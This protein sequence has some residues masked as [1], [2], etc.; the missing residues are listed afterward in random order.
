MPFE[1]TPAVPEPAAFAPAAR[2]IVVGGGFGGIAAALRLRARGYEVTLHDR[3]ERLGGRAAVFE[4][5][6]FRHDAG[7]TV[8]CA[9]RLFEELFALFGRTL[10]D[11]VTL[12]APDPWYR[13]VYDDGSSFDYGPTRDA[14]EREIARLSPGDVDNYA[15]LLDFS[16]AVHDVAFTQLSDRPFHDP[17]FMARQV[18]DLLR[19]QFYRTVWDVARR[20]FD[21]ERLARAFAIQPLLL[22]GNPLTTTSIYSLVSWLEHDQGVWFAMGGTGALVDALWDLMEDVGIDIRLSSP[23]AEIVVENGAARG[24]VLE[25]GRRE[26]AE[27]VVSNC[28]P[29]HLYGKMLPEGAAGRMPRLRMRYGQPSMGLFVLYFGATRQWPEVAHHTIQFSERF[30]GLLSDIFDHG[31][32][33]GDLSLYVHRP[34]ATDPS[35]APEGCDSFYVLCP[36]PNLR[37]EGIDWEV[38]APRLR[39]AIVDKLDATLLPGLREAITAEFRMTPE[40]FHH[41]YA[42]AHGAGFSLQ[43]LFRQSAF[44]RF[45]NRGEG[46]RDLYL[47][48]AGT[49]PGAG[50]PGVVL[51]A[52]V[53]D[54]LVPDAAAR[55]AG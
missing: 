53:L 26:A 8:L 2:A 39:D 33:S 55:E 1:A 45:H 52:K 43:P 11:H 5:E 4:N 12:V 25:D 36:V 10:S 50:V 24:V 3:C 23:V 14:T 46:I 51:S 54:S 49:H 22:G 31:R 19:L 42:S 6:G 34:T 13:F 18:P 16:R 35:F 15:R 20:H 21:D 32:L 40:D 7:P 17:L 30:E 48:G 38:E 44:F 47:V 28:D 9:P 37:H 29:L 41:R 27:V